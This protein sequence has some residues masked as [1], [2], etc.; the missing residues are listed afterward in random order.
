MRILTIME[1]LLYIVAVPLFAGFF[2]GIERILRSKLKRQKKLSDLFQPFRDLVGLIKLRPIVEERNFLYCVLV[3]TVCM[4]VAGGILFTRANFCAAIV[5]FLLGN[6]AYAAGF[7]FSAKEA[8]TEKKRTLFE[9]EGEK[10]LLR[11]GASVLLF[12]MVSFAFYLVVGFSAGKGS[13][14]IADLLASEQIPALLFP[15]L[16]LALLLYGIAVRR[17]GYV[18]D[19]MIDAYTGKNLAF[20]E[21]GR[22]YESTIFFG[23]VFLFHFSGTS[24]TAVI[25]LLVILLVEA[26][27]VLLIPSIAKFSNRM[28]VMAFSL[29]V[30]LLCLLNIMIV[31]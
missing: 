6:M 15:V 18:D 10:E 13:F 23:I 9:R 3:Y 29:I 5:F 16:L 17:K 7:W 21:I 12:S 2:S 1:W 8:S 14:E 24:L 27:R 4:A 20:L 30:L 28:V 25:G 26:L 31:L 11:T 19:T 22:W